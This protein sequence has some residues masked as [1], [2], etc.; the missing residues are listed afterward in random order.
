MPLAAGMAFSVEPGFY[1]G[2]TGPASRHRRV[3]RGWPDRRTRYRANWRSSRA[4]PP[5]VPS[6]AA[7]VERRP[8]VSSADGRIRAP[9]TDRDPMPTFRRRR[10]VAEHDRRETG[11]HRAADEPTPPRPTAPR[12]APQRRTTS[13]RDRESV[14]RP[15]TDRHRADRS[16]HVRA[17]SAR[18]RACRRTTGRPSRTP[19]HLGHADSP[20]ACL[21]ATRDR[22][23][24]DERSGGHVPVPAIHVNGNGAA[25]TGPRN[26]RPHCTAPLPRRFIKSRPYVPMHELRRRFGSTARMTT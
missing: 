13:R 11:R 6:D 25:E 16:G 20:A 19:A 12:S 9:P 14:G 15:R 2:H 7:G 1:A 22:S 24:R 26:D 21:A 18:F 17:A 5:P 4:E 8:G 23:G 10:P 3:R